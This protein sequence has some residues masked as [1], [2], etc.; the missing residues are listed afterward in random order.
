MAKF[1]MSVEY[2][3]AENQ[4]GKDQQFPTLKV[5]GIVLTGISIFL[6]ALRLWQ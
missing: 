6:A 5:I 1:R 3:N 4:G 2:E